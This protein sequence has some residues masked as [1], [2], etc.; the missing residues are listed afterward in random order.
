MATARSEFRCLLGSEIIC[1]ASFDPHQTL[2]D[3]LRLE[4]GLTGTK[5]G[6]AEGDCGACTVLLGRPGRLGALARFI[7]HT[8]RFDKVWYCR[9]IDIARHWCSMHPPATS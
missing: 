3:F 9:R 1:L 6:C 4:K 7:E 2:L 8:R 5:E